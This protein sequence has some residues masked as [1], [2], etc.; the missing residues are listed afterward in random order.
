MKRKNTEVLYRYIGKRIKRYRKKRGYTVKE[1]AMRL[2][3]P[4]RTLTSY[5][6]GTRQIS[7]DLLLELS[8]EYSISYEALTDINNIREKL[9]LYRD[10]TSDEGEPVFDY[11][12]LEMD[13]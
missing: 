13:I 7:V 2:G 6:S 8:R 3:I 11:G 4:P 1:A 12:C 10:F 5:E 9:R